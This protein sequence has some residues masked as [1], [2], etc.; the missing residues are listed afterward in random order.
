MYKIIKKKSNN[1]YYV[2]TSKRK[3]NFN[4]LVLQKLNQKVKALSGFNLFVYTSPKATTFKLTETDTTVLTSDGL[5]TSLFSD[6]G[7]SEEPKVFIGG[8]AFLDHF[9]KA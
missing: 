7:P 5:S 8:Q 9:D 2:K 1:H 4:R 6:H 3:T